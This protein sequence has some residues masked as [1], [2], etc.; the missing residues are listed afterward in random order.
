MVRSDMSGD[1]VIVVLVLFEIGSVESMGPLNE[2][3]TVS[4][5]GGNDVLLVLDVLH[6]RYGLNFMQ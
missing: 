2:M 1:G 3:T 5:M 6:S 4:S